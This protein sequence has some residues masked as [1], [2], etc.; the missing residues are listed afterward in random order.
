LSLLLLRAPFTYRAPESTLRALERQHARA[1]QMVRL[2]RRTLCAVGAC[3]LMLAV[4]A[5]VALPTT[6]A[7]MAVL[8]LLASV[9]WLLT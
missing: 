1:G 7:L 4:L 6:I 9:A 5:V 3:N 8:L 2:A